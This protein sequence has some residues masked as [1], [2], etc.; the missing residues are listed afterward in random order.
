V[1]NLALDW[2]QASGAA[3]GLA[4]ATSSC[5]PQNATGPKTPAD[6]AAFMERTR[7]VGDDD[8]ALAPVL[9]GS[10]VISAEPLYSNVGATKSGL[11]SELRGA[12]LNVAAAQGMTAEWLDRALE[13]HSAGVTLG[14]AQQL[15]VDPFWL[16]DA[17]VDIDVRPAKDGFDV[18]VTG[19]SPEEARQILDRANAFMK[20][21]SPA[22]PPK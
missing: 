3:A 13:C 1:I 4:V 15:P 6:R 18:A 2:Q 8:A 20:A 19:Y 11:Q 22:A 10:L 9:S 12:T 14:H 5:A 7:C 17:S 21:K 16:P